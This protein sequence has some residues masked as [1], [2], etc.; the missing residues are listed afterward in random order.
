MLPVLFLPWHK[1][2]HALTL[3]LIGVSLILGLIYKSN[4]K[5][6][7]ILI[8]VVYL[9]LNLSTI[10]NLN[11]RHYSVNR[12]RISWNVYQF[13]KQNYPNYPEG[14][15]LEFIND[16]TPEAKQWGSSKQVAYA[17]SNLDFFKVFYKN[18]QIKIYYEDFNETCLE[19]KIELSSKKFLENW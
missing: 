5:I 11:Q 6:L 9:V 7:R 14:I 4:S 8:L 15:C 1:F 17:L 16:T 12:G 3:P 13:F 10:Y 2:S 18:N 19:P